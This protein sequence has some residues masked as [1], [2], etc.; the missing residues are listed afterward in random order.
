MPKT[1]RRAVYAG[2]FD[3]LTMGHLYM[4]REGSRL[5]DELIV[6]VGTNPEKRALFTVEE[7]LSALKESTQTIARVRISHFENRFLVEYAK[8]VGANYILRGIRNGRDYEY[9]A[10]MRHVNGDLA[11]QI[12]TVFLIPP[13]EL[14][15][16]SS[17]FVKGLVGP[18]GW[19]KVVKGYVPSAVYK[20]FLKK[21]AAR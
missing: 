18:K 19:E 16:V 6:A 1:P 11:P 3:P 10:A 21:R 13:R 15:E 8:S 4:I 7:R 14:A 17:S 9:E 20:Q 12:T 2:S 5:F